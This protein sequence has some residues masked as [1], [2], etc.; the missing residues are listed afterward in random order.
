[1]NGHPVDDWWQKLSMVSMAPL[2]PFQRIY[3]GVQFH[4]HG[5]RENAQCA[6]SENDTCNEAQ[7]KRR[8]FHESPLPPPDWC[9]E[10]D[11]Q[12]LGS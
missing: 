4:H 11:H 3:T 5:N 10:F 8:S 2:D 6:D 7:S 12:R 9:R 1:M